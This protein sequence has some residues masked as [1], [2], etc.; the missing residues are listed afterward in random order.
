MN[1]LEYYAIVYAIKYIIFS[2]HENKHHYDLV[3]LS[4][5]NIDTAVL[6]QAYHQ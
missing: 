3:T 6:G 4:C 5:K 1:I 2:V